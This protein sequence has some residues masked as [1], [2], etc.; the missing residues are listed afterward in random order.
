MSQALLWLAKLIYSSPSDLKKQHDFLWLLGDSY[1]PCTLP[2][3]EDTYSCVLG[4]PPSLRNFSALWCPHL[5][6]GSWYQAPWI[7][8]LIPTLVKRPTVVNWFIKHFPSV[9]LVCLQMQHPSTYL[10]LRYA[11][12]RELNTVHAALFKSRV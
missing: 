2:A 8:F 6:P 5:L 4:I 10:V 1:L 7:F 3:Q 12:V 9:P 11:A